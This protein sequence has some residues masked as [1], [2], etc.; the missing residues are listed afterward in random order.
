MIKVYR[1]HH[2]KSR[3]R[4][5]MTLIEVMVA[6]AIMLT[7]AVVAAPALSSIMMLEQREVAQELARTY[8]RLG[9]E[10]VL[11]NLTFR[12]AYHLD[13]NFYE[14]QVADQDQLI[15]DEADA[16][17][18]Y[19]VTQVKKLED[20]TEEERK[21]WESRNDF[22]TSEGLYGGKRELPEHTRLYGVYTPQYDE[23][24][25]AG[26][27]K[28]AGRQLGVDLANIDKDE[29]ELKTIA[30]SYVFANGFTEPTVVIITDAEDDKD[31]YTLQVEPLSG[32]VRLSGEIVDWKDTFGFLPDLPPQLPD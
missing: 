3:A 27:A 21:E 2:W 7:M 14:I 23:M 1:T 32:R 13:E 19:E 17:V 12:I 25:R 4:R 24:I 18:D 9:Q 10:A 26:M 22:Q 29:E 8:E 16:R 20:M 28:E 15:F 5:A 30:Y 31:G 6:V 11:R